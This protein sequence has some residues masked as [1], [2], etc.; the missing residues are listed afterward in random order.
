M[1]VARLTQASTS[2]H[3]PS[4]VTFWMMT[5]P[6]IAIARNDSSILGVRR[7]HSSWVG[8]RTV[9]VIASLGQDLMQFAHR[10]QLAL[11]SMVRGKEN[12]GHA[13]TV[14]LPSS[15]AAFAVQ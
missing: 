8:L 10:L 12:S 15:K 7:N 4:M 14:S 3:T 9:R 5:M 6:M 2:V 11:E 1:P 13:A